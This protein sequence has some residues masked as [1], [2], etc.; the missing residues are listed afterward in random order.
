[1]ARLTEA[2]AS[3][4]LDAPTV[5][6]LAAQLG[7]G[8]PM[9][10]LR[11]AASRGLVEQI[12]P[13]WFLAREPLDRLSAVLREVGAEGKEVTPAELR[14][15]LGL[16]RKYLIPLLEWAD[17]KGITRRDRTGRRTLA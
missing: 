14:N 6:D 3:A 11:I 2:L 7:L 4:G 8:D 9:G 10:A 15:R 1:V 17:R 5:R 12:T 16:S 13:E